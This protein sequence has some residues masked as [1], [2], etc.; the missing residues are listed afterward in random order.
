MSDTKA[1]QDFYGKINLKQI[2]NILNPDKHEERSDY[3]NETK[4]KSLVCVAI[5]TK[6]PLLA[7][8]VY[9][10]GKSAVVRVGR[11]AISLALVP[12]G[13]KYGHVQ[14]RMN[15]SIVQDR[16]VSGASKLF[17]LGCKKPA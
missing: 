2:F 6:K 10:G 3:L 9:H 4:G 15:H 7:P 5:A 8:V 13:S 14:K 11:V 16:M 1:D 17:V 12:D